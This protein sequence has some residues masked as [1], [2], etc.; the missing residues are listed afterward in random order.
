MKK[1]IFLL[2][3]S[4]IFVSIFFVP[5]NKVVMADN[6]SDTIEDEINNLDLSSL[7]ELLRSFSDKTNDDFFESFFNI[8]NGDFQLDYN[9]FFHYLLSLFFGGI[10]EIAPSFITLFAIVIFCGLINSVKGSF[11]SEEISSVIFFVCFLAVILLFTA[12]LSIYYQNT[13]D[14]IS[15]ISRFC[16][17]VT[18]IILTLMVASGGNASVAL[19]K[20]IVAMFSSGIVHL[21]LYVIIPLVALNFIFSVMSNFSE[22]VKLKKF[23]EFFSSIIKWLIGVSVTVFGLFLSIQGIA[24]GVFDGISMKA[25]KYAISNSIPLIGGFLKDGFDLVVAGSVLIKNALG[26]SSILLI[27]Y[28][29]LSPIMQILAFSLLLKLVSAIIEPISDS[30]VSDFCSSISKSVSYFIVCI[31]FVAFMTFILILLMIFSANAFI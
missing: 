19:F 17:V 18:P 9:S 4:L 2:S 8:V 21:V 14:V 6:L 1:F 31:L 22:K 23:S 15:D 29:I 13:V 7:E 30:R 12:T 10:S 16:E 5:P 20:P 11:F 27:F 28:K 26:I 24:S 25:A 3:I